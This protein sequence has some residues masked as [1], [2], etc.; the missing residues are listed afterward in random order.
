MTSTNSRVSGD[1]ARVTSAFDLS[2]AFGAS[3]AASLRGANPRLLSSSG[4]GVGEPAD[5]ADQPSSSELDPT[6]ED[7]QKQG[8]RAP[9]PRRARAV[10]VRDRRNL[11]MLLLMVATKEPASG[12]EFID[13]VRECSDGAF[14]LTQSTV[15]HA[16]HRLKN[17]R[18]ISIAWD[19]GARRY[20]LTELGARIL[21][22][23]LRE[24]TAFSHG[25]ERVVEA[26]GPSG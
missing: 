8:T 10:R 4:G 21:T 11:D 24:W 12:T 1:T 16:L 9:P 13:L 15:Y 6:E 7:M 19:G 17:D 5:T 20:L 14:V 3:A 23:R 25:F 22:S 2:S 26:T 18:L